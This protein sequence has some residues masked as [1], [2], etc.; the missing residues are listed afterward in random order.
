M[1]YEQQGI[2]AGAHVS[3]QHPEFEVIPGSGAAPVLAALPLQTA[4]FVPV[5]HLLHTQPVL[6]NTYS[7]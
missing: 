4:G 6:A 7:L 5:T 3:P 1:C 2:W